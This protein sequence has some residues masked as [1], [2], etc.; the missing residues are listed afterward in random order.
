M[1]GHKNMWRWRIFCAAAGFS[2]AAALG[3]K[4]TYSTLRAPV[5]DLSLLEDARP[6]ICKEVDKLDSLYVEKPACQGISTFTANSL[7]PSSN[8]PMAT[9]TDRTGSA[10]YLD[11]DGK[12]GECGTSPPTLAKVSNRT[13]YRLQRFDKHNPYEGMH[14]ALNLY[15]ALERLKVNTDEHELQVILT[16]TLG[17]GESW[18]NDLWESI[19]PSAP[20]IYQSECPASGGMACHEATHGVRFARIIDAQ[21]SGTSL[22]CAASS[23]DALP[24]RGRDTSCRLGVVS[25]FADWMIHKVGRLPHTLTATVPPKSTSFLWVAREGYGRRLRDET[26]DVE[27][28]AARAG[29]SVQREVFDKLSLQAMLK[30]M[31]HTDVLMGV[32]GAGLAWQLFMRRPRAVIEIFGGDRGPEN[33]HYHNIAMFLGHHYQEMNQPSL[34]CTDSCISQVVSMMQNAGARLAASAPPNSTVPAHATHQLT[35]PR[36]RMHTIEF[37]DLA[38]SVSKASTTHQ[39]HSLHRR[40]CKLLAEAPWLTCGERMNWM[41]LMPRAHVL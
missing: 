22:L 28:F 2:H 37:L 18:Q 39:G 21:F 33:R 5:E 35:H 40:S 9:I 26:R 41:D 20:L 32:H 16:D 34:K 13:L 31:Q 30:L 7:V 27:A 17:R 19:N 38:E 12:A 14:A 25:R 1:R 8:D 4:A 3:A 23:N 11:A 36:R 15:V 6:A 10:A 24:G 29:V